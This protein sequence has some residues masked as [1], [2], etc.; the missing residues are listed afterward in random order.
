[1]NTEFYDDYD[2][3]EDGNLLSCCGAI[4]DPDCMICPICKEHN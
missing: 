2:R 3:D 1:M 4:L